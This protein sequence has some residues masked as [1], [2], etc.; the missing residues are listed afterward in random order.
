MSDSNDTLE[1]KIQAL[2]QRVAELEEYPI[3]IENENRHSS[4]ICRWN[5]DMY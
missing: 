3:R 2:K 4:K 5:N 1:Q